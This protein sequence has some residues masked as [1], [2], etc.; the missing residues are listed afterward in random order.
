MTEESQADIVDRKKAG[1]FVRV[2]AAFRDWVGGVDGKY[3]AEKD[4]YHL[5]V[6]YNCPWCHRVILARSLLGLQDVIS[7]D[8]CFPNRT[9]ESHEQ[10]PGFWQFL[11]Q[12]ADWPTG[13]KIQYDSCTNDTV[14]GKTTVVEIYKMVGADLNASRPSVPVLFDKKTKTIVSNESAEI[15]EMLATSF[16]SL[17][18]N[19]INL[20]PAEKKVFMSECNDWI[21]HKINNG[22]YK[23]GF[24]SSQKAY[25]DAFDE[26]FGALDKL[27]AMLA[28]S[29]FVCGSQL[30]L[31]DIRLFPTIFRHDPIYYLRMK[32]NHKYIKEY[33]NLWK[34]LCMMYAIP[35]VKAECPLDQMKQGYFGNTWN[36]V[37][38]KGPLTYLH[39]L[40][41][42]GQKLNGE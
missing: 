19:P 9:D 2:K 25:E 37:V 33:P 16:I 4:R 8:V 34:W 1:E 22:A 32:L 11:P 17:A 42:S 36:K 29:A 3:P 31:T 10:G 40:Q 21:Y 5:Y 23:A 15:I 20:I 35:A 28:N 18:K 14:N 26:Y 24:S 38:P 7:M 41:L 13:T 12:G 39:D 6:A 27:D 30:T